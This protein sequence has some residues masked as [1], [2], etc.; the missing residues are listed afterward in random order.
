MEKA[1]CL[2]GRRTLEEDEK[3]RKNDKAEVKY[4]E[5]EK[6]ELRKEK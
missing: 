3:K 1:E 5:G 6:E 4:G 2:I